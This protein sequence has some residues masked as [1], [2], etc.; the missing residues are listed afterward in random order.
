MKMKKAEVKPF[1]EMLL[2][3]RARLRGDV[4]TLADAALSANGT[5]GGRSSVPSHMAVSYTHLTLPTI[6]LV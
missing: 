3:L 1:K 2:S 6:L 4:S 5:S